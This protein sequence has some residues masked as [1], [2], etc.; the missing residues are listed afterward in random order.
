MRR[1]H[2][3]THPDVALDPATP[4]PDWPL[5]DHGVNRLRQ[6]LKGPCFDRVTSIHCSTERKATD[7]A[8]IIATHLELPHESHPGLGENDRSSTGY[9]PR[10]EFERTADQ[11]FAEPEKN[12]RGWARAIDEQSRI[13]GAV[14][15]IAGNVGADGT[16]LI[17]AHGAVGALLMANLLD[18]PISRSLDQPGDG[19][20]NWFVL[21]GEAWTLHRGWRRIDP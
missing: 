3:L 13:V 9:L 8:A 18:E 6:S 7:A 14:R 20:G 16:T 21:D 2:F 15:R 4:V 5:S 17:I 10:E 1:L 19:G 12:V 11:F